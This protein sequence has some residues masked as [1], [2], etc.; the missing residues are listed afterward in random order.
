MVKLTGVTE[1]SAK[2]SEKR[3]AYPLF[4]KSDILWLFFWLLVAAA[5]WLMNLSVK[6][7]QAGVAEIY[8]HQQLIQEISLI[9]AKAGSF[10]IEEV[11]GFTF[12]I[13]EEHQISIVEAPCPDQI[14]RHTPAKKRPGELIVCVPEELVIEI[15]A[16]PNSQS[17]DD[18]D[19]II[20]EAREE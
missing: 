10:S 17:E 12:R 1:R 2:G 18:L 4:R 11:P 8:Y 5:P 19:I 15:V 3:S 7:E 6:P 9:E 16:A 13:D 14:C 20:G